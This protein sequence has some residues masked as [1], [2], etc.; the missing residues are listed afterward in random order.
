MI[1]LEEL[2]LSNNELHNALEKSKKRRYNALNKNKEYLVISKQKREQ[3]LSMPYPKLEMD[4][5]KKRFIILC[6]LMRVITRLNNMKT[7][8]YN[9]YKKKSEKPVIFVPTH[10]GK[11]DIEIVYECIREHALL[12]SGTEDRMHGTLNGW[13]LEKNGVNYVDRSDKNDRSNAIL[14]QKR[15]LLNGVNIMWFIEGTWNISENQLI[16]D[17]S[18]SIIKT[19]L[20]CDVEIVP[21]GLH[22][23]DNKMFVNFGKS[24]KPD[25]NKDLK[26]LN[27]ELRDTLATL[28]WELYEYY[29]AFLKTGVSIED[30]KKN[31][32]LFKK[33]SFSSKRE[34]IDDDYWAKYIIKRVSE[35]PITDLIEECDYMYH[36]KDDAHKFFDEFNS[37]TMTKKDGKI[38]KKRI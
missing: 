7:Y 30:Y 8:E 15:D 37:I 20:E 11:Y 19:A 25:A 17:T 27:Q 36:P 23:I 34:E 5:S 13:F 4:K 24:Y 29:E 3:A 31:I 33:C 38:L 28:K 35:W 1:N 14:K 21:V 26:E 9:P 2:I 22:Q 6:E 10:I 16:Y 12:L 32:D 18:Y